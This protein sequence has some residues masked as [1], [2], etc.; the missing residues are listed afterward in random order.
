MT[1]SA[2]RQVEES[3]SRV[4]QA[5]RALDDYGRLSWLD[6]L[7]VSEAKLREACRLAETA[8][9]DARFALQDVE[10]D[11]ALRAQAEELAGE[12]NTGLM[13]EHQRLARWRGLVVEVERAG[14][15]EHALDHFKTRGFEYRAAGEQELG[16]E[17]RVLNAVKLGKLSD[18]KEMRVVALA[19]A[20][21]RRVL[22][23][24]QPGSNLD[25]EKGLLV[26]LTRS[27]PRGGLSLSHA[28]GRGSGHER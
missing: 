14:L 5:Q 20:D 27:G 2:K 1:R 6:K 28:A 8:H 10:R 18:G 16:Q 7:G 9:N 19:G 17:L 22:M 11:P 24:V 23:E 26:T 15:M 3:S 4:V 13:S 25:I 21:G 12:H